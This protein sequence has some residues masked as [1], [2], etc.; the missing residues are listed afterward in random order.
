[1]RGKVWRARPT[2]EGGNLPAAHEAAHRQLLLGEAGRS[3]QEVRPLALVRAK[4]HPPRLPGRTRDRSISRCSTA[5]LSLRSCGTGSS[6]INV[7]GKTPSP[8]QRIKISERRGSLCPSSVLV[9]DDGEIRH[10]LASRVRLSPAATR[11]CCSFSPNA[12]INIIRSLAPR[13]R[14][15]PAPPVPDRLTAGVTAAPHISCRRAERPRGGRARPA[16]RVPAPGSARAR[17]ACASSMRTGLRPHP[18][19]L[20]AARRHEG[21]LASAVIGLDAARSLCSALRP[22]SRS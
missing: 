19:I 6:P 21:C 18:R 2:L 11:S 15:S 4:R 14:P 22:A 10:L 17:R 5:H 16:G 20:T 13:E 3:P 8:S 9:T 7:S 1:M 12:R